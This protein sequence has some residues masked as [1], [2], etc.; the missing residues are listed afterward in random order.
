MM[1]YDREREKA[2]EKTL[3]DLLENSV[4]VPRW[5]QA[6]AAPARQQ[7][8]QQPQ[9]SAEGER[10]DDRDAEEEEEQSAGSS[11]ESAANM[12]EAKVE[13]TPAGDDIRENGGH[14]EMDRDGD[15]DGHQASAGADS[16][17]I[18]GK[19]KN[20]ED[21]GDD[22]KKKNG[23]HQATS[24]VV[25][26]GGGAAMECAS[27]VE[28]ASPAALVAED[29]KAEAEEQGSPATKRR[30]LPNAPAGQ[31]SPVRLAKRRTSPA[32]T[33]T[34][35]HGAGAVVGSENNGTTTP[36]LAAAMTQNNIDAN[37]DGDELAAAVESVAAA[38]APVLVE[39]M[40]G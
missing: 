9:Q 30:R 27:G 11:L 18:V 5:G 36:A 22:E 14:N 4:Y 23:E 31:P 35:A 12:S 19:R 6:G 34:Q 17:S 33:T 28:E 16:G 38:P 39:N 24:V 3:I 15:S 37:S 10:D 8:Q 1:A 40:E 29:G 13:P 20:V 32:A 21:D 26:D 7:Q 25:E 2:I